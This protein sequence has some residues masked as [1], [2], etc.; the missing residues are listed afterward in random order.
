MGTSA[1]NDVARVHR[2]R[3]ATVAA[4][5]AR[6]ATPNTHDFDLSGKSDIA[7]RDTSGNTAIWL[8]NGITILNPNSSFV[9]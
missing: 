5:R 6:V 9:D 7:C 4:F 2:D 1:T 3:V 8:M